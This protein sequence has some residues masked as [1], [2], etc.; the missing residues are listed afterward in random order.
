MN[1]TVLPFTFDI[2]NITT[3]GSRSESLGDNS[4]V[5]SLKDET[6]SRG[7]ELDDGRE[8]RFFFNYAVSSITT[9]SYSIVTST[10]TKTVDLAAANGVNCL[11]S[12]YVVC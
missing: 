1:P 9:T 3:K 4:I 5:S 8:K 6:V 11:P 10:I 7:K 2:V 12:G